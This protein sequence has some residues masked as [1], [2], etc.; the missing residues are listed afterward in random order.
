[1]S[2]FAVGVALGPT[3][4]SC[5]SA[6]G[7]ANKDWTG[8]D[9]GNHSTS[10]SLGSSAYYTPLTS[11]GAYS[12]LQ[13]DVTSA[14]Q[15]WVKNASSNHGLIVMPV[16]PPAPDDG[17]GQCLSGLGNFVVEINYLAP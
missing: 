17:Q 1:M 6:V 10:T 12:P 3:P 7:K 4:T 5:V 9:V 13:V 11:L 8:L 16:S 15:G 14:V 2:Y